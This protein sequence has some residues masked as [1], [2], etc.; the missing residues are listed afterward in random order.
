MPA[1]PRLLLEVLSPTTELRRFLLDPGASVRVGRTAVSDVVLP[2][3]EELSGAHFALSWDGATAT[4]RDLG[5][6]TGTFLGGARIEE[7]AA[8]HGAWIRAGTTDLRLY[9]ESHSRARRPEPPLPPVA[10]AL[11]RRL[12]FDGCSL[13]AL[14]DAARTPRILDLLHES[15]DRHQSLF[16]GLPGAALSRVAPY[17]VHLQPASSPLL[18]R[19]LAEGWGQSWG[20]YVLSPTPFKQLRRHFRRH[21][22]VE[23]PDSR[24]LYFRLYDPRVLRRFLPMASERQL[25]ELFAE[26]A[27]FAL[28]D[29][30]PTRASLF[31]VTPENTLTHELLTPPEEPAATSA[32]SP[33]P[34]PAPARPLPEPA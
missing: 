7:A 18:R 34:A 23:D 17:L 30:L 9:Q 6:A 19:L 3:D 25:H 24:S 31:T 26:V 32:G 5:S 1:V 14:L 33:A 10:A 15:A 12:R 28:E 22:R 4:V 20:V 21:L 8:R 29:R 16:E 2:E 11:E 27:C 13:Y